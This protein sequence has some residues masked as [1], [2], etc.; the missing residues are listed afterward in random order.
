MSLPLLDFKSRN[1]DSSA[2]LSSV[3]NSGRGSE[4]MDH[5]KIPVKYNRRPQGLS[6]RD[7]STDDNRGGLASFASIAQ[8]K[9]QLATPR[10]GGHQDSARMMPL[11]SE[12]SSIGK[13]LHELRKS[14]DSTNSFDNQPSV[15]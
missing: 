8:F 6:H 13:G 1:L 14:N 12:R 15:D 10:A 9:K 5:L 2:D 3:F 7:M 11:A 4:P